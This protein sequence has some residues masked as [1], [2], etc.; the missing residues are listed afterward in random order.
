M[1]GWLAMRASRGLAVSFALVVLAMLVVGSAA[2]G[3]PRQRPVAEPLPVA[4]LEP[5]KTMKLWRHLVATRAQRERVQARARAGCRPLRAVFYAATDYLRLATKLA[6]NA[7]PCAQYYIFVPTLVSNRTQS[8]PN[9]AAKIR[10]LGSNFHALA[11][12]QY[13]A[14]GRWGASTGS[15]WYV[16]GTTARQRMAAAGYDVSKGDTWAMNEASTAVRK[17]TGSARANLREFLRGLYEGDG[18]QPT[19]GDLLIVGVGQQTTDASLYQNTLQS[20]YGDSAFWTDMSKYVSDWGQETYGDVRSWAVPG[21]PRETR[22]E[23]LNDYL[24]H[25]LVLAKAGPP[26]ID[27]ARTYLLSAYSPLA[28]AAWERAAGYGWTMVSSDQ[29]AA[30][31]SAQVDALRY[32]SATSGQ[33]Q[34]HWGFAWAPKNTSGAPAADFA[35][36]TGRILDRLASAIQDSAQAPD[37]NDPGAAACGPPGQNLWCVGDLQG[38]QFNESWKTFRTWTQP[39]LTFTTAPQTIPAG[40]PSAAM[41]LA[42]TTSTGLPIATKTTL[43]VSLS[44]SS[45]QGTF[46]TSPAGPWSPTLSLA[47]AAGTSTTVSF[48]YLDPHAGTPVVTATAKDVTSATQTETVT[49]G[50]LVSVGIS[51]ATAN[52]PARGALQFAAQGSDSFGNV[53]PVTAAWSLAPATLGTLAPSSGASTTFT[54]LRTLGEGTLTAV[55]ATDTGS[56]S[57]TASVRVVPGRLRIGSLGYRGGKGVV[58]LALSALDARGGAVSDALVSVLVRRD[59]L[60]HFATRAKTGSAGGA[61]FRIPL[62]QGGCLTTTVRKV[63]AAGF[64]WDGRTP[65]NRFCRPRSR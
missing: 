57:A 34:D 32:Y 8:R 60:R 31:V 65:A 1:R 25:Q 12:V 30:Y 7:S 39:T 19:R 45:A 23:Y 33:A 50:P 43:A 14:W 18:T 49:P 10:A 47:V 54:A 40:T 27:A 61:H 64:A 29:M 6:A 9:V 21:A 36:Q 13:T 55:V 24:Q 44:S 4:S 63:S 38:A 53:F 5:A 11:E 59:G 16:A 58:F 42:L 20:W 51:P 15:S 22:R 48:Y 28:N 41:S 17:D 35:A 2:P 46:S 62:R 52:V 37:P 3:T 26:T 56:L